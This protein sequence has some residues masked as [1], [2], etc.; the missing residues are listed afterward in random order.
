MRWL[1][2]C[3]FATK[4]LHPERRL[5]NAVT[6][7][8]CARTIRGSPSFAAASGTRGL[9]GPSAVRILFLTCAVLVENTPRRREK[10]PEV[11]RRASARCRFRVAG[12]GGQLRRVAAVAVDESQE[13]H[14]SRGQATSTTGETGAS[15]ALETVLMT[16]IR[17]RGPIRS[18]YASIETSAGG[19]ANSSR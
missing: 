11:P 13:R 1:R 19:A 5:L 3:C 8:M 16:G 10:C 9:A 15:R 14:S 2:G 18:T 4:K 12:E 6:D 17:R 7:E